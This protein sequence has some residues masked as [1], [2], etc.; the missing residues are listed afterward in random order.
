VAFFGLAIFGNKGTKSCFPKLATRSYQICS[1][2]VD[3][4]AT[5][6]DVKVSSLRMISEQ[7]MATIIPESSR[8][9]ASFLLKHEMRSFSFLESRRSFY[10]INY[11]GIFKTRDPVRTRFS[12]IKGRSQRSHFLTYSCRTEAICRTFAQT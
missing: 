12:Q 8:Q 11:L 6:F 5:R 7:Y 9:M 3:K 10:P 2:S 1:P 4:S